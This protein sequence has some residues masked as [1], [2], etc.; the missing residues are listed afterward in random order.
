MTSSANG[1]DSL[2]SFV[3]SENLKRR[4]LGASQKTFVA[5]NAEPRFAEEA[6]LLR[7]A[8]QAKP[9]EKVGEHAAAKAGAHLHPPSD[10]ESR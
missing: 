7:E 3:I 6:R 2:V 5:L 8:S 4:H 9:G 1:S 10:K